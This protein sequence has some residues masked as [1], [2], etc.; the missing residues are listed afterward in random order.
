MNVYLAACIKLYEE[1]KTFN[2]FR[3][4]LKLK[5]QCP[6]KKKNFSQWLNPKEL[7]ADMEEKEKRFHYYKEVK[8]EPFPSVTATADKKKLMR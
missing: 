3:K 2:S 6:F 5:F 8:S 4:W 7:F 1:V